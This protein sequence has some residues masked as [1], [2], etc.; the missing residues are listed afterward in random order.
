MP[1]SIVPFLLSFLFCF[2]FPW[3]PPMCGDAVHWAQGRH[4][5][6][7][8]GLWAEVQAT[9]WESQT[10][11]RAGLGWAG[12]PECLGWDSLRLRTGIVEL[13]HLSPRWGPES[14]LGSLLPQ[15]LWEHFEN[16]DFLAPFPEILVWRVW[17]G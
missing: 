4:P 5:F 16:P 17:G 12:P 2:R 7:L 10:L 6:P 9:G 1:T 11:S 14:W 8:A 13:A 3:G 15:T